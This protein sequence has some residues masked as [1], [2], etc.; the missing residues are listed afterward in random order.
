MP[1]R[2]RSRRFSNRFRDQSRNRRHDELQRFMLATD[3]V[4][5]AVEVVVILS[6][7]DLVHLRDQAGFDIPIE[8]IGPLNGHIDVLQIRYGAPRA[9]IK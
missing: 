3:S 7:N 4:T 1:G 8:M 6:P 9:S 5:V 2:R